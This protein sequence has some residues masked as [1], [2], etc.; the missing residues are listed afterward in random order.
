MSEDKCPHAGCSD[1]VHYL[2]VLSG[3]RCLHSHGSVQVV[4]VFNFQLF[5][6]EITS[7]GKECMK[8]PL[9]AYTSTCDGTISKVL[10]F[11]LPCESMSVDFSMVLYFYL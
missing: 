2:K 9:L 10:Y 3:D 11:T 4:T 1:D 5:L 8:S 6:M 7:W